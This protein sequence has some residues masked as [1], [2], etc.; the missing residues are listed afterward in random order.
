MVG[1]SSDLTLIVDVATWFTSGGSRLDP[2][3]EANRS[4]IENNIQGSFKAFGDDDH[5]GHEDR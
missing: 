3:E 1:E 4:R 2:R 5:D